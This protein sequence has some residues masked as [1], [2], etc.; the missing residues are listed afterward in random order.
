MNYS[1]IYKLFFPLLCILFFQ[2]AYAQS[3]V[4]QDHAFTGIVLDEKKV[5]LQGAT[6]SVQEGNAVATT[7][8]RGEFSINAGLRDVLI[9]KMPGFLSGQLTISNTDVIRMTL[10]EA[11]IDAGDDDDVYIPFGIRKKRQVSAAITTVKS[12]AV[13]QAPLGDVKNLFSGRVSG[14]Y[15]PQSNTAPGDDGTGMFIRSRNSFG[16]KSAKGYVDGVQREF[17]DMDIAEI[18]SITVLKDAASLAWYGLRG[19]NGIVLINTKKGNASKSY[20]NFDT[21]IGVQ[22]SSNLQ[23]PLNSYD[24]AQLYNEAALND[25]AAVAPFSAADLEAYKSGADPFRYPNNNYSRD[26]LKKSSIVQ[27]YVLSAGGGSNSIRYFALLS[28]FNQGG[29]LDQT[30]APSFNSNAGYKKFNFR[31]NVDFDVNKYLTIALNAGMRTE[32]RLSPGSGLSDVL[33]AI[34]ETPPNAFPILNEDGSLGGTADYTSN[35]RGLLQQRGYI[36]NLQ[37]VLLATLNVKQKLD[38]WVP[39]LSANVLF[40]YDG[41]GTYTS[42]ITQ[43]YTVYDAQLGKSYLTST[44]TTYRA[45][46]Y[47][48][49]NLQNELWIGLDYDRIFGAH[50]INASVRGQ[51]FAEKQPERLDSRNQGISA[52]VEYGFK[53][54]YFL[55]L[56]GGYSGSENISPEKRYGFFPAVAAGWVVSE[57]PFLK[58]NS[59]LNYFKVRASYGTVGNDEIGGSRFA[60]ESFYN[61][62][63]T[64]GGYPFGN[65]FAATNSTTESNLGNPDLTWETVKMANAGFDAR[66]L[67]NALSITADFYHTRREDILT[68]NVI[69]GILGQNIGMVNAGIVESKGIDASVFYTRTFGKLSITL[70]GNLLLSD[71]KVIA[72]NGQNG[73]PEYQQTLGRFPGAYLVFLSDGFYQDQ[74]EID[75]SPAKS[76]LAGKIVPG[77]IRYRDIGG[78]GGKPDGIINNDDRVRINKASNPHTYYGFGA[79]LR[80]GMVDFSVQFQGVEG[81]TIDVESYVNSGPFDLNQES[82]Y[83]W[84]PATAATAK[85]PRLGL[86]DRGNNTADSDFWLRSGDFLRLKSVEA[87]INLPVTKAG[88]LRMNG[89]RIFVGGY[90]LFTSN[91]LD[92]NV[93]PEIPG[94]GRGEAYPYLKTWT[95]GLNAKF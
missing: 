21:Q 64:G 46:G 35:P 44:P 68:A 38:F 71:S 48:A 26:Y 73:L 51:R 10:L 40:S 8:A 16:D 55:S 24:Y 89:L 43:Q 81:R 95:V 3:G 45:A 94:S 77:D 50:T 60:F 91:S 47:S 2:E 57:E 93:D 72:E 58:N 86:E 69:P 87:G 42:G 30:K 75:N 1:N 83:R 36:S 20:I 90:N 12:D 34:Y 49:N 39:G 62:N 25:G 80:Y 5:P 4:K 19:G 85:Y 23:T 63:A 33:G 9:F 74:A 65:S 7:N 22:T 6:V 31:G 61:R 27:R 92:V 79:N 41:S 54:R 18:E 37:R 29:L 88:P 67:N 52:R 32:N 76:T 66:F 13:P 11:G 28:Y 14:L 53:Q 82:F 59:V 84:T 70:N 56:V 17:G 78:P 15:L